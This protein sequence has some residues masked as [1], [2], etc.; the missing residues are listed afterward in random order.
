MFRASNLKRKGG[1]SRNFSRNRRFRRTGSRR[2]VW[3]SLCVE[4]DIF[5]ERQNTHYYPCVFRKKPKSICK[6]NYF[7]LNF[8]FVRTI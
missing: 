5:H 6:L 2:T 8:S 3:C 1:F 7:C 4:K